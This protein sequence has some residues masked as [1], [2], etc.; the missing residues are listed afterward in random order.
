MERFLPS[1]MFNNLVDVVFSPAG[2]IY[3]LEYGTN[4][5]SQNMD[6]RLIHL[7]YSSANRVPV[8]SAQADKTIGK[9]PLTVKFNGDATVDPDGDDLKY[10]W[11]FGDG[12]TS[13]EKSPVHEYKTG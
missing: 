3:A 1:M 4:W 12:E 13:A 8:A 7:T 5:F 9:T 2:D 10:E 11:N 6:A